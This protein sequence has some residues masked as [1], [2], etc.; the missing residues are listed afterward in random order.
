M[1]AKG[2][3]NNYDKTITSDYNIINLLLAQ[4][5][6]YQNIHDLCLSTLTPLEKDL[7][8]N[9][10]DFKG[11]Y[12]S[13]VA[14][15]DN[16]KYITI[17]IPQFDIQ[18]VTR[19]CSYKNCEVTYKKKNGELLKKCFDLAFLYD[20]VSEL[21]S[22]DSNIQP[23]DLIGLHNGFGWEVVNSEIRTHYYEYQEK[24]F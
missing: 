3:C 15:V 2:I 8:T 12:L 16:G 21:N 20:A 1:L 18:Y 6:S 24:I 7:I 23:E 22:F 5:R 17:F 4:K 14:Q 11:T 19:E 9:L 13:N 10:L